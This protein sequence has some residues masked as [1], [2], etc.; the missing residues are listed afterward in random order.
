MYLKIVDND[1]KAR[2]KKRDASDADYESAGVNHD[3]VAERTYKG[4]VLIWSSK[5]R[6]CAFVDIS[7][8]GLATQAQR[9]LN[10]PIC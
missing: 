9:Q 4:I 5:M 8:E 2:G 1:Q 7:N 10:D 6:N 3:S